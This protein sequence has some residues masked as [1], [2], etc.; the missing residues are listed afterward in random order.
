MEEEVGLSCS[1]A[2][3]EITVVCFINFV[4]SQTSLH[5]LPAHAR[6]TGKALLC[7]SSVS[8]IFQKVIKIYQKIYLYYFGDGEIRTHGG[9]APT[10][11][12]QDCTLN[13]SDT[14]P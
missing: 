14:P 2:L 1:P 6:T 3:N 7:V 10:Q 13:R 8:I 4:Y 5:S 9:I 12:F 11:P